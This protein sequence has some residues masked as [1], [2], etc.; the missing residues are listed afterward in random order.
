MSAADKLKLDGLVPG[1]G[2]TYTGFQAFTSIGPNAITVTLPAPM[3]G[4]P[5]NVIL[6]PRIDDDAQ[7]INYYYKVLNAMQ[8]TII[9]ST[10]I[11]GGVTWGVFP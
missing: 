9:L 11:N 5:Y 3:A 10:P 8:F 6:C 7:F 1:A 4:S 2:F